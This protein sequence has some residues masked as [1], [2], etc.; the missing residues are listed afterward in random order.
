MLVRRKAV[1]AENVQNLKTKKRAMEDGGFSYKSAL[2]D[3]KLN[4][5]IIKKTYEYGSIFSGPGY[6][7]YVRHKNQQGALFLLNLLK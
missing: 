1:R 3:N 5:F 6:V 2:E 4:F 7:I